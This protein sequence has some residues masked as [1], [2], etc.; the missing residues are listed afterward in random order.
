MEEKRK[1]VWDGKTQGKKCLG[2]CLATMKERLKA[3]LES[4]FYK[5][6]IFKKLSSGDE[7]FILKFS[8]SF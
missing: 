6:H 3:S 7:Y 8:H 2:T 4:L 1:G 5:R